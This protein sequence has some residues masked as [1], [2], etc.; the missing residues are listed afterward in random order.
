MLA[1]E[2]EDQSKSQNNNISSVQFMFVFNL[3]RSLF[4]VKKRL[5]STIIDLCS[6]TPNS[7]RLSGL[8]NKPFYPKWELLLQLDFDK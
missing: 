4:F 5:P 3:L 7:P 1:F 2:K 6:V 8:R